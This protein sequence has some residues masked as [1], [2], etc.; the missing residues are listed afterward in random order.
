MLAGHYLPADLTALRSPASGSRYEDILRRV[1][2]ASGGLVSLRP[3]RVIRKSGG[4][5]GGARWLPFSVEVRDTMGQTNPDHKSLRALGEVCGV[6]KLNVGSS[7]VDMTSM[8]ES[9]LLRFLEYGV[10]DSVIVLEYLTMLWGLHMLPPVTISGGGARAL[11]D[12]IQAYWGCARDNAA[13]RLLFQGLVS[14]SKVNADVSDDGL[15][16][17]AVRELSPCD[18]DANAVH[19]A[20]KAAYHGGWNSCLAPGAHLYQTHDWDLCSAYPT[21]MASIVDPDFEAGCIG[22]VVKDRELTLDDF[23]GGFT[24]P[25]VG[26]VSWVFPKDVAVPCLPVRVGDSVI[27]PRTSV[28]CGAAQGDGMEN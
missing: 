2:S 22:K 10:N 1:T 12:A 16:Y 24:T 15:S 27:Y 17:Y 11:R 3:V 13:F 28:G 20:Y 5:G 7:I 4:R 6:P 25:F 26:F 8:R 21:A 9:D 14:R 18:G 19:S 23:E